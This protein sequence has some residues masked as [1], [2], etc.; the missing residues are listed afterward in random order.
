MIG[1]G[2][3]GWPVDPAVAEHAH[4]VREVLRH[5]RGD[6]VSV[7]SAQAR[8]RFELRRSVS[9]SSQLSELLSTRFGGIQSGVQPPHSKALRAIQSG[10]WS[11]HARPST[12]DASFV[13]A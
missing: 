2:W 10:V 11:S 13:S 3:S 4:E 6:A 1:G 5:D 12:R 9:G 7:R 8:L